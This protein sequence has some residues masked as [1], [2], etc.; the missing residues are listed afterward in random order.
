M[1]IAAGQVYEDDLEGRHAR[2]PADAVLVVVT[3]HDRSHEAVDADA[4]TAHDD[5]PGD[6]VPVQVARVHGLAV[7]VAQ[8]EDVADFDALAGP[9]GAAAGRTGA[10][11]A[12]RGD[13]RDQVGLVVPAVIHIGHVIVDPVGA[14]D[15]VEAGRDQVVDDQ[16][17]S[18]PVDAEG[19]TET[20][21]GP[22]GADLLGRGRPELERA[23]GVG[24]LGIAELHVAPEHGEY[25]PVHRRALIVRERRDQEQCLGGLRPRDIQETGEIVDRG[26]ALRVDL[27]E[28]QPL[29]PGR[30]VFPEL[31]HLPVGPVTAGFAGQD[32]VFARRR[33]FDKL[34]GVRPAHHPGVAAHGHRV[35]AATA[36]YVDVGFVNLVV[37]PVQVFAIHVERVPV[38]HRELA[39]ADQP[40]PRARFVP[41]LRLNLVQQ[42]RQLPVA[43][44]H[45]AD[46]R[47]HQ[48]L[49]RHGQAEVP[50]VA[51]LQ[52]RHFAA[53][54]LPAS[55]FSPQFGGLH[56]GQRHLLTA[57]GVHLLAD[58][59]LDT[60][61]DPLAEGQVGEDAGRHLPDET[62]A[63]EKLM[64]DQFRFA[65]GI[66]VGLEK[67]LGKA[68]GM[69]VTWSGNFES[70]RGG[71]AAR[72]GA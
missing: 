61:F 3:L 37:P 19:R 62:G 44:D 70:R 43:S 28:R 1:R 18:G 10:S 65:L 50:A 52:P 32:R 39:H 2:G 36:E 9:E 41:E 15:Q 31:G 26:R 14:R 30:F 23:D 46:Q 55:A 7:L 5:R 4:V 22:R 49:V 11:A 66:A 33:R 20:G 56:H 34:V 53:D 21:F 24:Q 6:V 63:Q 69:T 17:R 51:V 8:L 27:L 13:V 35:E 12:G 40:A 47:R 54:L 29:F 42:A 57:D 59:L 45:V 25:E 68:H 72:D 48:F 16:E 67:V 64:A 71:P 58:D 38:L 60:V